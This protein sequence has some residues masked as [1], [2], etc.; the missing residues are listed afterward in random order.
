MFV[1]QVLQDDHLHPHQLQK[2]QPMGSNEFDHG[3]KICR[4]LLGQT[5]HVPHFIRFIF[6]SDEQ[7]KL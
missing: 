1:W 4:W 2:V 3:I 5:V 7:F 6:F